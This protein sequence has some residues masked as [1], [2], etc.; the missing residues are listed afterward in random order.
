MAT[1]TAPKVAWG[2]FVYIAYEISQFGI[3][4]L[5]RLL[6]LPGPHPRRAVARLDHRLLARQDASCRSA[7]AS[8]PQA[9][10]WALKE[11]LASL[12][13]VPADMG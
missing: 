13:D 9:A 1:I 12:D 2:Q 4:L 6:L 5:A 8:A 11:G 3:G 10:L 7:P